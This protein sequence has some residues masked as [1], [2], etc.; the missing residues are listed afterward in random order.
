[1]IVARSRSLAASVLLTACATAAGAVTLADPPATPDA[2][3]PFLAASRTGALAS[4]IEPPPGGT[5]PSRIRFS[6][7]VGVAWSAPATIVESSALFANWADTPGLVESGDGSIL[8]WW[9]EKLASGTYAY[10]I[11][12]ARSSDGGASWRPLGWLQ[13]DP[14]ESEHG[15]VSAVAEGGV[16]R[17][18]WLD[19]RAT[20]AGG[21]MS[22]RTTRVGETVAASTLV[23]GAVCDCCATAAAIAPASAVSSDYAVVAY[24]DRTPEEIRDIRLARLT[25]AGAE[26]SPVAADGWKIAG[27]PV[28]GPA[29][30]ASGARLHVAWFSGAFDKA[31]VAFASSSDGGATFSSPVLVDDRSP[32]GRVA[33]APLTA[34]GAALA[35]YGRQG[36]SAELRVARVAEDGSLAAPLAVATTGGGRRSGVPRLAALDGGRLLALWTEAGDGPTRLRGAVLADADLGAP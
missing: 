14:S 20:P 11:R 19:G 8:A 34:G 1:M 13:D 5:G 21:A 28:N 16:A 12:L 30:V 29:V 17:F 24:R 31:R 32:L 26:E 22:L 6:R 9:L 2:F 7:F 36:E 10:G 25:A 3:A 27:C 23:D 15:F 18:F 35:W 4:W 33:L